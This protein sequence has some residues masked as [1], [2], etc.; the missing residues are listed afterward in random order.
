[1]QSRRANDGGNARASDRSWPT[2]LILRRRP[3]PAIED[4]NCCSTAHSL[5][6]RSRPVPDVHRRERGDVR[7]A[8]GNRDPSFATIC[9]LAKLPRVRAHLN[10]R[11]S[12]LSRR[13][14]EQRPDGP[15][16]TPRAVLIRTS[17]CAPRSP[18]SSAE[19]ADQYWL[20]L[21]QSVCHVLI[22]LMHRA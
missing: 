5:N 15:S 13:Y 9:V 18:S 4:F 1:M 19:G 8:G 11:D 14:I 21:R 3:K 20:P 2:A 16:S 17:S 6:W 22:L 12:D 7:A 10:C